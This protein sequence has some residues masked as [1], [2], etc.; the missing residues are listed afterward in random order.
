MLWAAAIPQKALVTNA[1]E[2]ISIPHVI[3]VGHS[4]AVIAPKMIVR[5]TTVL[6]QI[7]QVVQLLLPAKKEHLLSINVQ[8]VP[9]ILHSHLPVLALVINIVPVIT[10][11]IHPLVLANAVYPARIADQAIIFLIAAVKAVMIDIVTT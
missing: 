8:N 3:P 9:V 11:W 10:I 4:A 5:D 2:N 7:S 1:A 6:H